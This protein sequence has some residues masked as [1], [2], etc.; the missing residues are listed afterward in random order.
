MK[1][2]LVF[3]N[4]LVEKDNL[5][6]KLLPKL[7][8]SF[9]NIP[10]IHLDPTENLDQFGEELTVIDVVENIPGPIIIKEINQLAIQKIHSMHDFDLAYNLKL[11]EK[12]G[13]LKKITIFGLPTSMNEDKALGWLKKN[14]KTLFSSYNNE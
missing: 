10:F 12:L 7:Q 11:L 2:I 1:P 13:K 4:P 14:L 6:I 3:G 9:P 8:K 5:A